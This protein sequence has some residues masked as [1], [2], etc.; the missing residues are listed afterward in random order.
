M[1]TSGGLFGWLP[2]LLQR[3][4]VCGNAGVIVGAISGFIITMLD[5][6]EEALV[7]TALEALQLWLLVW[8]FAWLALLLIF[9]LFVRWSAA[10]VAG[11]ALANAFLVTGVTVLIVWLT[12]MYWLAVVIG[13]LA[14]MLIGFLLCQL[15]SRVV[16]E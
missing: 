4:G 9:T 6:T 5:F 3:L 12:G 7:L 8:L 10:S 1:T 16:R 2:T 15:Y 11:P 14:G 13:I